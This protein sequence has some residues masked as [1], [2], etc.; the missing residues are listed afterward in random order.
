MR[1]ERR[2]RRKKS[3]APLVFAVLAAL[4]AVIVIISFARGE[5]SE[6]DPMPTPSPT[7]E[8]TPEPTPTP[9]PKPQTADE[10]IAQMS[11]DKKIKQMFIITADSLTGVENSTLVGNTTK[12]AI[13][14]NPVGGL[15][16]GSGNIES[17]QQL[18]SMLNNIQTVYKDENGFPVLIGIEEEGGTN[19]PV[20]NAGIGTA[21]VNMSGLG[22]EEDF[23]KAY[24]VGNSIGG[25]L[26]K[27]GFNMTLAP[28]CDIVENP[29]ERHFGGD[30]ETAGSLAVSVGGGI[31][32]NGVVP[33]YKH[34]PGTGDSGTTSQGNADLEDDEL[35]PFVLAINEGADIIMVSNMKAPSLTG[36]NAPCSLSKA[37]V[38][39]LLRD[40]M[41]HN[42]L[43]MTDALSGEKLGGYCSSDEACV[44]AIDAGCDL[45]LC[46]DSL[47]SA[48][49]A[50]T[51]AVGSGRLTEERI[52]ESVKRILKLKLSL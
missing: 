30:A 48:V 6:P 50:V 33:V 21:T 51:A 42:G 22:T 8:A 32:A 20:A 4:L 49:A 18:A 41:G 16:Y 26:S 15:I 40:G 31:E 38:T 19:S 2:A 10:F 45:L 43:V 25:Y 46:P 24:S 39:D 1:R 14:Q 29:T 37:V 27:L 13:S 47:D 36:G 23:D 5:K 11:L 52:N 9:T 28:L 17:K 12:K 44:A 34:F 3:R 7:A 35:L